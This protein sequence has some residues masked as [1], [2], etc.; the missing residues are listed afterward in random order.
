MVAPLAR[1]GHRALAADRGLTPQFTNRSEKSRDSCFGVCTAAVVRWVVA[2]LLIGT[3][4]GYVPRVAGFF[5]AGALSLIAM[6]S[7]DVGMAAARH[8]G[9]LRGHGAWAVWRLGWRNTAYRPARSVLCI[10]LIAF[11]TF[12]IVA[13]EAFK[14]DESATL[15][16]RHSG[17]GGYPLLV[18]TLLPVVHDLNDPAGPRRDEP[19]GGRRRCRMSASIVSACVQVMMRAA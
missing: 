18:E 9:A 3:A 17:G 1:H 4:L 7:L 13:V 19:S 5:G 2:A 14:R 15:L 6:L 12:V 8:W 10:A 11:A 16:D